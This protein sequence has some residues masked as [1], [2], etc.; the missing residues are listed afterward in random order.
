MMKMFSIKK[1]FFLLNKVL[2]KTKEAKKMWAQFK[3]N[4]GHNFPGEKKKFMSVVGLGTRLARKIEMIK[5]H[6]W[7]TEG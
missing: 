7:A 4:D 2:I 1:I 5:I 3:M 6:I